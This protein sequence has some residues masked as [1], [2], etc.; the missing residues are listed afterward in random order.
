LLIADEP[1]SALDRSNADDALGVLQ[2]LTYT[3]ASALIIVTHDERVRGS[4]DRVFDL[5]AKA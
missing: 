5:G 1:T 2:E 4:F 3:N